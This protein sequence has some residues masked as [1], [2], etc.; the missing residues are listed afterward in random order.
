MMKT[1]LVLPVLAAAAAL[2][3]L[4]GCG[5][6]DGGSSSDPASVARPDAP[7]FIEAKLRPS[8]ALKTNVEAIASQVGIDGP[9]RRRSSKRSKSRRA[10]T[11]NRS[12]SKRTSSR[13]WAKRP[14]SS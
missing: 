2:A 3:I 12:T 7:V 14:G 4:A 10:R 6:G 1:C 9:G 11:A 5:G 8:G 13:G